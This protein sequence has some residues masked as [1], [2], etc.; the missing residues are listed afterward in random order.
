VSAI[1]I[2]LRRP[3]V[4]DGELGIQCERALERVIGAIEVRIGF[5][6]LGLAKQSIDARKA[7]PRRRVVGIL[8][9]RLQVEIARHGGIRKTHDR[10]SPGHCIRPQE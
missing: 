3:V 2:D 5:S 1:N 6:R 7:R 10:C 9:L 8:T 4:R